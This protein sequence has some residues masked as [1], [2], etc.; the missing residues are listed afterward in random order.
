MNINEIIARYNAAEETDKSTIEKELETAL[1]EH[2]TALKKNA[3]STLLD[4]AEK[5]GLSAFWKAYLATPSYNALGV[6]ENAETGEM[7]TVYRVRPVYLDELEKA[8]DAMHDGQTLARAKNYN[9]MMA[10]FIKNVVHHQAG[11]LSEHDKGEKCAIVAVKKFQDDDLETQEVD[12][13]GVSVGALLKQLRAIV[14]TILPEGMAPNMLK[15]DVR[16]ILMA[17]QTSK[18]LDFKGKKERAMLRLVLDAAQKRITGEAYVYESAAKCFKEPKPKMANE[19]QSAKTEEKMSMVPERPEAAE[20]LG[21]KGKAE[22][23]K[24]V[25]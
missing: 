16:A 15:A 11:D 6:R 1:K 22:T 5:D 14:E 17:A 8:W 10:H 13:S 2:N 12:F 4:T 7:E 18:E 25:A 21:K 24:E 3:I 20:I 23:V 19:Q 9:R